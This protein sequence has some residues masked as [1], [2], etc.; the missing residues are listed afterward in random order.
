MSETKPIRWDEWSKDRQ[1]GY[2]R[3]LAAGRVQAAREIYDFVEAESGK[4][5][6]REIL[7]FIKNK[8]GLRN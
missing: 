3:G 4:T 6:R 2:L 8:Y 7:E 1:W 5:G